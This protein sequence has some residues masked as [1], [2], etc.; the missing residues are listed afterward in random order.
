[1]KFS[2]YPDVMRFIFSDNSQN[3]QLASFFLVMDA[4]GEEVAG[5]SLSELTFKKGR[6]AKSMVSIFCEF[7]F[8]D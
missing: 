8:F 5:L 2:L 6:T 3:C 1:M 7:A 4:R